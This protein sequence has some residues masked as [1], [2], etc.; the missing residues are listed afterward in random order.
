MSKNRINIILL[1]IFHI[2]LLLNPIVIKSVHK[3]NSPIQQNCYQHSPSIDKHQEDCPIC[4]FEFVT[5]IVKSP[6]K[7]TALVA[8]NKVNFPF[9]TFHVVPQPFCYFQHRAPPAWVV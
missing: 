5:F 9:S 6:L 3:H 7:Y 4:R 2:A 1:A 8:S